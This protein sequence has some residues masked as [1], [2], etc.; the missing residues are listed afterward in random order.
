MEPV[1][2]PDCGSK[3]TAQAAAGEVFNS[4]GEIQT[5]GEL[6]VKQDSEDTRIQI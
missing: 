3:N 1:L 2:L 6:I 5:H 4:E